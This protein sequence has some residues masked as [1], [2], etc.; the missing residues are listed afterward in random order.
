MLQNNATVASLSFEGGADDDV[1][2][3]NGIGVSALFFSGDEGADT[4]I[5]NG[6][7]LTALTFT[8]GADADTLRIQGSEIGSVS[9]FGGSGSDSFTYNATG[10]ATSNITFNGEAGSDFFGWRGAAATAAFDGGP[11][12]DSV[13][14]VGSGALSMTGG[15]G[16][17][18][19]RFVANPLADVTLHDVFTGAGDTSSDMLDFSS[20]TGGPVNLDLRL[21]NVW[22]PQSSQLR[23]MLTDGLAIENVVGTSFADTIFGNARS[24]Y[25]AGA[26]FDEQFTG[27]VANP[28]GVT[29]W[30]F[31]DFDTYTNRDGTV[32]EYVY[33]AAER[34]LI[35]QRVESVY[36]GPNAGAP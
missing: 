4:L 14:I 33:S 31:L 35:R 8:G 5:N 3:N 28:R 7:G 30:V 2:V 24:N 9:F 34:E 25:I 16:D 15:E 26:D 23:V 12:D 1:L 29:Q 21:I 6:R 18:L 36:R 13:M 19:Y 27:P 22:Q 32:G 11:G 17:D 10:T 20:F